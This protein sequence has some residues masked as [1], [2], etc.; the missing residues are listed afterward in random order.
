MAK[1]LQ[2]IMQNPGTISRASARQSAFGE[3]YLARTGVVIIEIVILFGRLRDP[4][5][6]GS[7]GDSIKIVVKHH[8]GTLGDL[9]IIY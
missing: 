3:I 5:A 8:S 9:H 2:N 6:G 7:L 4:S 1:R